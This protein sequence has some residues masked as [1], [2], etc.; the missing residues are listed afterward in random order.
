[1]P[2][3]VNRAWRKRLETHNAIAQ[4]ALVR[5]RQPQCRAR[6]ASAGFEQSLRTHLVLDFGHLLTDKLQGSQRYYM[7]KLYVHT[8][9]Q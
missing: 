9:K 6:V 7:V 4:L 3:C 8:S 1:M 5:A 2:K